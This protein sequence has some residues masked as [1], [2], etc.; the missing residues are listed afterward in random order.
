[1]HMIERITDKKK[2]RFLSEYHIF[3]QSHL[4]NENILPVQ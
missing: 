1:M 3:N 4:Q 2:R